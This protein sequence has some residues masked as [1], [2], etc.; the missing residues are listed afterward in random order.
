MALLLSYMRTQAAGPVVLGCLQ[1]RHISLSDKAQRSVLAQERGPDSAVEEQM[2]GLSRH[3][4]YKSSD[5]L[6]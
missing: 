2:A 1:T 6:S 4:T 3:W 5:A